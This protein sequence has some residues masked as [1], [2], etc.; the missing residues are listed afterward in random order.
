MKSLKDIL[1]V[2]VGL[3]AAAGAIFYF[4]RFVTS[5]APDGGHSQGWLALGLAAVA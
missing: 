2:L 5:T 3:A 4:Y 1:A